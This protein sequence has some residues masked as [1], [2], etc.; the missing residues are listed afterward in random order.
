[1]TT[2]D[3][4]GYNGY[5]KSRWKFQKALKKIAK[6]KKTEDVKKARKMARKVLKKYS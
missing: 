3:G 5:S 1:M 2:Y 4:D 6:M